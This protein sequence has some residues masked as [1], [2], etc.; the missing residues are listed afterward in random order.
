MQA[1]R[2][3]LTLALAAITGVA[4]ASSLAQAGATDAHSR[5]WNT[6]V[7]ALYD[8]YKDTVK[9][10]NIRQEV[11][12]GG[13]PR[14]PDFYDEVRYIDVDSGR[15]LSTI[16]WERDKDSKTQPRD[17]RHRVHSIAVYVYD[18]QGRVIR[19]Y[20]GTY[21]PDYR[22]APTQTLIFLHAYNGE[23]HAF[24]AFDADGNRTYEHCS[25]DLGG[26]KVDISLDEDT[27]YDAMDDPNSV[28]SSDQY[29]I[30][31]DGIPSGV[32]PYLDPH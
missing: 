22:K 4:Q 27:I 12:T 19:D 32:D 11:E 10:R 20:S 17:D 29:K 26:E 23:T 28:M 6:F 21:L 9:G 25:G 13:Y 14:F 7:D 16:L 24:R 5:R 18:D 3:L 30:C 15:L 2:I 31:F 1:R 8:L